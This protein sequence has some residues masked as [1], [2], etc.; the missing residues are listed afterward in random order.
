MHAKSRRLP[1][2]LQRLSRRALAAGVYGSFIRNQ[3][4]DE[5]N[6]IQLDAIIFPSSLRSIDE[7]ALFAAQIARPVIL[8]EGL[9]SIGLLAF[10]KIGGKILYK[11]SDLQA[12]LDRHYNPI[13]KPSV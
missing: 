5:K 10:Y 1:E 3:D 7:A 2:G 9:E 11:Q 13:Q 12:M 6:A 4:L 8:P